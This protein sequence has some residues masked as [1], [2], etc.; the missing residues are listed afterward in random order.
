MRRALMILLMFLNVGTAVAQ[1]SSVTPTASFTA[2]VG[3]RTPDGTPVDFD[4]TG[5]SDPNG[6]VLSYFWD[7]GDGYIGSEP[8][9]RHVY[10]S[11]G[12]YTVTLTVSNGTAS[13]EQTRQVATAST[14]RPPTA[15]FTFSPSQPLTGH[16]VQFTSTA[17]DQDHDPLTYAWTFGDGTTSNAPHPSKVFTVAG[18]YEVVLT[19]NDG[20]VNGIDKIVTVKVEDPNAPPTASF[21]FLPANPVA[22]QLVTFTSTSTDPNFDVLTHEWVFGDGTTS[23]EKNPRKTYGVASTYAVR[24]TVSDGRGGTNAATR[25]V[26]VSEA[27]RPPAAA[28]RF[29]IVSS[30]TRGMVV[31]FDSSDSRDPDGQPLVSYEWSFGDGP[32][33]GSTEASPRHTYAQPGTYPV[34]LRVSDGSLWSD[35]YDATV[36]APQNRPPVASF[37]YSPAQPLTGQAIQFRNL[38][39]D[40]DGDDLTYEWTFG[41]G[42]RSTLK[43][44]AKTFDTIGPK[45]VTLVVRDGSSF[46]E[47]RATIMVEQANRPPTARFTWSPEKPVAGQTI[48]FSNSSTDPDVDF[49]TY[50]WE[51]GDGTTS[52]EKEPK[53]IY[54]SPWSPTVTLTVTDHKGAS[55]AWSQVI[56]VTQG[57]RPPTPD[58]TWQILNATQTSLP[59]HFDGSRSTDL[60]GDALTYSW[61]FG[62]P[63]NTTAGSGVQPQHTYSQPGTYTVTLTVADGRSPVVKVSKA[64]EVKTSTPTDNHPPAASFTWSPSQ[65]AVGQL[66]TFTN[67][68]TDLDGDTLTYLWR[69][70]DGTTSTAKNPLHSF[71]MAGSQRVLLEASDGKANGTGVFETEITVTVPDNRFPTASF[72]WSPGAPVVGQAI[73]FTDA[74]TDPDGD[75]LTYSW[76]FGDGTT[77]S[78]RNPVKSYSAAHSYV[79]SLSVSDGRNG[80]HTVSK[81]ITIAP[82]DG[83]TPVLTFNRPSGTTVTSPGLAV[84]IEV[85][86][87][88]LNVSTGSVRL[89][90]VDVTASFTTPEV[91]PTRIVAT[92][93]VQLALGVN[94]LVAAVS[95][96]TGRRGEASLSVTYQTQVAGPIL[97]FDRPSGTTVT[98]PALPLVIEATGNELVVSTGAIHLNG[99]AVTSSFNVPEPTPA[100]VVANGTVQLAAG[101]NTVVAAITDGAGRRGEQTLTVT[102]DVSAGLAHPTVTA[103][104]NLSLTP[105]AQRTV[106]FQVRNNSTTDR[107][108][109]FAA[110]S[111][112][113][114]AVADPAD[115]VSRMI[116]A[117][118]SIGVPVNVRVLS[119]AAAG[120]ATVALTATDT[121][122]A[123][124][125]AGASF[126]VTVAA[127]DFQ[128]DLSPHNGDNLNAAQFGANLSYT[129]PAYVSMDVQRAVTLFYSSVQASPK[130]FVEVTVNDPAPA[131]HYSI[132]IEDAA[133]ARVTL[134]NGT[135]ENF[136]R[137]G[138]AGPFRLAAQFDASN[139]GGTGAYVYRVTVRAWNGGQIRSETAAHDV[140]VLILDERNSPYGA[141]WSI[142]VPR[143]RVQSD[144][145][146]LTDGRGN[147]SFFARPSSCTAPCSYVTP[148]G[149]W[150]RFDADATGYVR[151]YR[152]GGK[153]VFRADGTLD[154]TSDRFGNQTRYV[155]SA[156]RLERIIDPADRAIT[157]LYFDGKLDAIHDGTGRVV[158]LDVDASG[159]L[160]SI[161]GPD[162]VPAYRPDY[163]AHRLAGWYDRLGGRWDVHYDGAGMLASTTAPTVDVT[164]NG[165]TARKR[166]E[167][168]VQSLQSAVLPAAPTSLLSPAPA[169]SSPPRLSVTDPHGFTSYVVNNRFGDPVE[170]WNAFGRSTKVTRDRHSRVELATSASGHMTR[171]EWYDDS[172]LVKT[173]T[174]LSTN[175]A[176]HY[177]YAVFDQ[178]K[179]AWTATSEKVYDY[180][181]DGNLIGFAEKRAD[182]T[183]ARSTVQLRPD[184]RLH[185]FTDPGGHTRR[186]E[187]N[188]SPANP[189]KNLQMTSEGV[190]ESRET[191]FEYGPY[192]LPRKVSLPHDEI[193]PATVRK[194]EYDVLNRPSVSSVLD[195]ATATELA[196]T[197]VYEETDGKLT[198]RVTDPRGNVYRSVMNAL[199]WVESRTDARNQTISYKYDA[200]GNLVQVV[201]RRNQVVTMSYDRLH[202][203]LTRVDTSRNETTTWEWDPEEKWVQ[204]ANGESVNRVVLDAAGRMKEEQATLGGTTYTLRSRYESPASDVR[205]HLDFVSS[206]GR[207]IQYHYDAA[208][209]LQAVTDLSGKT[210]RITYDGDGE[211]DTVELPANV[212]VVYGSTSQHVTSGVS[213][214]LQTGGRLDPK[215]G[216][217]FT[218]DARG[219]VHSRW[220]SGTE[221]TSFRYDFAGRLAEVWKSIYSG[222][223]PEECR[224]SE[225]RDEDRGVCTQIDLAATTGTQ[226]ELTQ[227]YTYD[228]AGNRTSG[229]GTIVES[230]NWLKASGGLSMDYDADGN[231]VAKSGPEGSQSLEWDA[232]GNLRKVTTNGVATTFGY[233]GLGRRVRKSGPTGTTRYLHDDTQVFA[234]LD[235]TGRPIREYTYFPKVDS[236]LSVIENGK[237]YYYLMD[238]PGGIVGV[239]DSNGNVVN[240]YTYGP[241]GETTATENGPRNPLRFGAREHDEETGLYYNRARYYDPAVGRFISEDPM[242]LSGGVNLYAY[243]NNDPVNY[244]DS[245]GNCMDP[246]TFKQMSEDEQDEYI[247]KGGVICG[248][249]LPGIE[250]CGNCPEGWTTSQTGPM[251]AIIARAAQRSADVN[252]WLVVNYWWFVGTN[253]PLNGEA[254]LA[255]GAATALKIART[256][257][258]F[259]VIGRGMDRIIPFANKIGAEYFDNPFFHK[260]VMD[261]SSKADVGFAQWL[262]SQWLISKIN[263]GYRVIDVGDAGRG[264]SDFYQIEKW[265]METVVP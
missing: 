70:P 160:R 49:L 131:E 194:S 76:S 188:V 65:P 191:W 171:Y 250:A 23:I 78:A 92:G 154:Y 69:F 187:Y 238:L 211:I 62:D 143:I 123:A 255:R 130:G 243:A 244:R 159:D 170:S 236:P 202:R 216:A 156:G 198:T 117:G 19:V 122:S 145:L 189:W 229:A 58:F 74:S 116:P 217:G 151:T 180:D 222:P 249:Q 205:T 77:S 16:A 57:N 35:Y 9:M 231:L 72:T 241:F 28:F 261:W 21:E 40:V 114:A 15:D 153:A 150:S 257:G 64:V 50:L 258:R 87:Q 12:T 161:V 172:P 239:V 103:P 48:S 230:G 134:A 20:K 98:H 17:T 195:V 212:V 59:V 142:V 137:G 140:R 68:T 237:T 56:T 178:V 155:Y 146:L 37:D 214:L 27:N 6:Q 32:I 251:D 105:G 183:W 252:G 108:F 182:G 228:A 111:S 86:G 227:L 152:D 60:D 67:T 208:G 162:N 128:L 245:S 110:T 83:T 141:G 104:P 124:K 53:K 7:F 4:A 219:R 55:D 210:T 39:S 207:T 121:M 242:G 264:M 2:T 186:Y 197:M 184:G 33:V 24:L 253:N 88:Q 224:S 31:Q 176:T 192:G 206:A 226:S 102:Y 263:A 240:R 46:H 218:L 38:S 119:G 41:D 94:T 221:A 199:G 169:V 45:P 112:N 113:G 82:A 101:L 262:N 95:D 10:G 144:G 100:R 84:A 125:T 93:T 80:S 166:P 127:V 8:V 200:V 42:T 91:T 26:T 201:N 73:A 185:A 29:N 181:D 22:G 247:E 259:V 204:V 47:A 129:T 213:F 196:T 132:S 5:S 81:P 3:A 126:V 235:D 133:G 179:R 66:V 71:S 14:N 173:V 61:D 168:K 51:F 149:E 96:A 25:N 109:A 75:P 43:D 79:V 175:H 99:V 233:D 89:N 164:E 115:P 234:E 163:V 18:L 157:F 193:T 36:V 11:A 177:E 30:S 203:P 215:L 223:P 139:V 148:P 174:D 165:S 34:R 120:S 248:K 265:V 225:N 44:P 147:V 52:A 136:Y 107:T 190:G 106:E 232:L 167:T 1:Q 85:A 260:D 90:G 254:V 118:A 135:T 138:T 246:N 220:H 63:R 209:A 54:T 97:K 256:K 158:L 13:A